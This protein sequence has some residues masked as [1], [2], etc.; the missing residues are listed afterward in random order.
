MSG[1]DTGGI[2]TVT[3]PTTAAGADPV[4]WD[5]GAGR[6]PRSEVEHPVLEA[7]HRPELH[8]LR[9]LAIALVVV[10]HVF[11][12]GR[13]SGGID[14]FLSISGFLFTGM[15][16][17]EAVRTGG[18]VHVGRYLGRIVRRLLPS[19]VLV[20]AATWVAG[21]LLLPET[22]WEQLGRELLA[23]LTYQENWELIDSQLGY[24]AAGAL[25]SPVQHFWSMSVQGQFYLVWPLV[26]VGCVLVSRAL[27][28]S[29]WPVLL[30]TVAGVT[31]ASMVWAARL[32]LAD[33][34][35]AYLHTGAR[36][37]EPALGGV[38]A[39]LALERRLPRGVRVVCGWAG[40]ALV[41]TSGLVLDGAALF[42]GPAALWPVGGFALV[43][44]A[45]STGTRWGADRWLSGR[46]LAWAGDI[47]YPL[48]LWH[49][50]IV[51]FTLVVTGRD[52]LGPLDGALV[53][54]ASVVVAHLTHT[55][56]ERPLT[57]PP[58]RRPWRVV[59]VGAL[60]VGLGAGALGAWS[61]TLVQQRE[62]ALAQAAQDDPAYPG[63]AALGEPGF[64][65][66]GATP[67]PDL[68]AAPRDNA[69]VYD[70]GC[71]QDHADTEAASEVLVCEGTAPGAD[72]TLVLTGGSHMVHY[73]PA[74]Q[75]VAEQQGWDVVVISRSG[76]HLSANTGDYPT[77]TDAL[78]TH[79]CV[80][81][82]DAA[83]ETFVELDPDAVL[84][85]GSTTQPGSEQVSR[86]FVDVWDELDREGI[87]VIGFRD[88]ARLPQGVPDCLAE[89][90]EDIDGCGM[91]RAQ[92]Y[93]DAPPW[94]GRDDLP[95][96]VSFVDLIDG[97][98]TDETCPPIVGDVVVYSDHSHLTATYVRTLAPML[99]AE[100]RRVAPQLYR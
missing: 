28:R 63:A 69:D 8:G 87:E 88:T 34:Q 6:G 81:W 14:V 78:P 3:A 80:A 29:V 18:A 11:G 4:G 95:G 97:V 46:W 56:V 52:R 50:P 68:A 77:A 44:A 9:G 91:P 59:L 45:G 60:V 27:R 79:S 64:G 17:R 66:T 36:L 15:L 35:V 74:L 16:A 82:N 2:G 1:G 10:F 100:L 25:T 37:W 38:L 43:M 5:G 61:S 49:W 33:Q 48:F 58:L 54:L 93:R 84:T 57:G 19:A 40:V 30:V 26:V 24:G 86:G 41:A 96:N 32:H 12:D 23:G 22:R 31:A 94:T 55:L 67:V 65:N 51:V 13:V 75:V 99:D 73:L 47:A 39:L 20:L 92:G 98:C 70:Q 76:C 90:P 89:Q 72:T 53:I 85:L 71:I 83:L 62:A 7:H 42:P 21:R